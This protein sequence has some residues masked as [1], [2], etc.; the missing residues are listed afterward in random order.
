[1]RERLHQIGGWL[2]FDSGAGGTTVTAIVPDNDRE[3]AG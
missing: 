2:E 1:M 3:P